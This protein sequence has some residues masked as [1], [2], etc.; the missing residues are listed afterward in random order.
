[1]YTYAVNFTQIDSRKGVDIER[2]DLTAYLSM[3]TAPNSAT[4]SELYENPLGVRILDLALK[5]R[6]KSN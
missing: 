1:I 2:K 3:T 6:A 4:A 5:D